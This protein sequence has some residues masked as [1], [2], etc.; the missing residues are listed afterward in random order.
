ME[1]DL[2][3][4]V[5][6]H[7]LTIWFDCLYFRLLS[8]VF[9]LLDFFL[10][11]EKYK[12]IIYKG[13]FFLKQTFQMYFV[14]KVLVDLSNNLKKGK[15]RSQCCLLA[16]VTNYKKNAVEKLIHFRIVHYNVLCMIRQLLALL[17]SK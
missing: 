7:K 4:K 3:R 10:F 15:T 5:N 2:K 16:E 17:L 14:L 11:I 9:T 12:L 1:H 8:N 6:K 13:G